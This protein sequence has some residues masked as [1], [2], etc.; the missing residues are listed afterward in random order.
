M[1]DKAIKV[2]YYKENHP[3]EPRL[4]ENKLYQLC[5]KEDQPEAYGSVLLSSD[6]IQES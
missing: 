2:S 3:H 5:L 4:K 6:F 1:E